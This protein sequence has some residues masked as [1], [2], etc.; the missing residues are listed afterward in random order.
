MK[1]RIALLALSSA[2]LLTACP[3]SG[4]TPGPDPLTQL[5]ADPA[6]GL[7]SN[8]GTQAK[9]LKTLKEA[10]TRM[11]S[12]AVKTT[13]LLAGTYSEASGETWAY[14]VPDGVTLKGNSAG[15]ILQSSTKKAGFSLKGGTLSD[16][17]LT[18]FDSALS[19]S[20]GTQTLTRL[21][22]K[23]NQYDLSLNG[24]A[25]SSLQDSNSSGAYT[26][27]QA[28]GLSTVSVSGGSYGG[29]SNA[30]TLQQSATAS[31]TN[32]DIGS[33]GFDAGG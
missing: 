11:G 4:G 19:A 16:L 28:A 27:V 29:T 18:G 32:S 30:L 13:V 20:S 3:G 33:G 25:A 22:F 10:L 17:T 5:Y 8:P 15:V 2:L 31:F 9:P 6:S 14:T 23:G 24:N 21:T 12:G 26:S 7:D 1:T